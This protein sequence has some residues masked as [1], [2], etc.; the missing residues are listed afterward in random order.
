M[1]TFKSSHVHSMLLKGMFVTYTNAHNGQRVRSFVIATPDLTPLEVAHIV[2]ATAHGASKVFAR[3]LFDCENQALIA[4]SHVQG[5]AFTLAGLETGLSLV[6]PEV[7]EE[8]IQ[9]LASALWA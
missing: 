1:G 3:P 7:S 8:I 4:N 6:N 5:C 9:G 2:K